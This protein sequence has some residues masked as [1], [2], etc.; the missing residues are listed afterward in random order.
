MLTLNDTDKCD[1]LWRN[2][3]MRQ[4]KLTGG[5]FKWLYALCKLINCLISGRLAW[6]RQYVMEDFL[7]GWRYLPVVSGWDN[8]IGRD[9]FHGLIFPWNRVIEDSWIITELFWNDAVIRQYC[10]IEDHNAAI[11]LK[12]ALVCK[13][14]HEEN[15][16]TMRLFNILRCSRIW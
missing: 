14:S 16:T 4:I 10:E 7:T 6:W 15:T 8:L 5:R 3:W 12:V 11:V 2:R 1:C 13:L 9:E